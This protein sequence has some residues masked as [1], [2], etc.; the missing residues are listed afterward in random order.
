MTPHTPSDATH[1]LPLG[2]VRRG[3]NST[4]SAGRRLFVFWGGGLNNFSLL[5]KFICILF[6]R[7][8][9]MHYLCRREK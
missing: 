9:E 6:C 1:P 3:K 5:Y 4:A 2:G 7:F 8:G